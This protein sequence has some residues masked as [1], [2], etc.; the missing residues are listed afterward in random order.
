[1]T[2]IANLLASGRHVHRTEAAAAQATAADKGPVDAEDL[3]T[4]PLLG[5]RHFEG[6]V[7]REAKAAAKRRLLLGVSK[8]VSLSALVEVE[9]GFG[10]A[11]ETF[12]EATLPLLCDLHRFDRVEVTFHCGLD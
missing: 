5:D 4:R 8:L 7:R 10:L 1:M 2:Y 12:L 9:L 6:M 3:L 11:T